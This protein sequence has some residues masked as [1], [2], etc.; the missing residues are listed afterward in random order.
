[1]RTVRHSKAFTLQDFHEPI[2]I[3]AD[4]ARIL[5]ANCLRCHGEFVH[6]IVSG[7]TRDRDG[8]STAIGAQGT[9]TG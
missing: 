8:T 3:K 6:D 2:M 5:Q 4:N 9:D 1:V 7:S